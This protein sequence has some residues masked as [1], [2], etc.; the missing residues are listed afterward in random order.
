MIPAPGRLVLTF[1]GH[2]RSSTDVRQIKM[3]GKIRSARELQAKK[4]KGSSRTKTSSPL[5]G[6]A[7]ANVSE[8][9][10]HVQELTVELRHK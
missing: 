9:E 3:S 2:F 7:S 8:L 1:I 5:K 6:E 10:A 4:Q